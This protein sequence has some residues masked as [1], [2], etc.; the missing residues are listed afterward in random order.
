[1]CNLNPKSLNPKP[2]AQKFNLSLKRGLGF[3]V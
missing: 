1:M 2:E 3:R